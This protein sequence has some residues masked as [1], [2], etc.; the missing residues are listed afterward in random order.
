MHILILGPRP[1]NASIEKALLA[2][3]HRCRLTEAA[4]QSEEVEG[5]DWLV[6]NGY[7]P[8]LKRPIIERVGG[9]VLNIHPSYLPYGRGIFP[10]FWALFHGWPTGVSIHQIDPGIDTGAVYARKHIHPTGPAETLRTFNQRL[11]D[12]ANRLF[13]ET[14]PAIAAG[15]LQPTKQEPVDDAWVARNRIQ[16]EAFVELLPAR[17]ETP[18]SVVAQCGDAYR[19]NLEFLTTA[20]LPR[21]A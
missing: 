20:D 15:T 16:S 10:L 13:L 1:R 21:C 18:L 11:L 17:W 8:I 6:V 19:G 14:W 2:E 5:V 9:R 12:E 3:G 4:L 7:A